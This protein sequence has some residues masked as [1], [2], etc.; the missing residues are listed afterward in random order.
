M[1]SSSQAINKFLLF[2]KSADILNLRKNKTLSKYFECL[3][4]DSVITTLTFVY[5]QTFRRC[6]SENRKKRVSS[7][8][9]NNRWMKLNQTSIENQKRNVFCV[10]E[11]YFYAV[12]TLWQFERTFARHS[13]EIINLINFIKNCFFPRR[14]LSFCWISS[15]SWCYQNSFPTY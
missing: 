13:D 4:I 7:L 15:T 1:I 8:N 2:V 11:V 12:W 9:D 5:F 14:R 3:W 10:T 6:R